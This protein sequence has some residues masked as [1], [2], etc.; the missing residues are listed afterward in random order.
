MAGGRL[1]DGPAGARAGG[2]RPFDL[3]HP[4]RLDPV[5]HLEVVEVLDADAAL[6]PLAHLADIV[7][8]AL[9]AGE[10]AGVH[11]D[12]IPDD[13]GLGRALD[14]AVPHRAAGDGAHL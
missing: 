4:E 7:L 8:E 14:D 1:A 12:A 10:G 2:K 9:E 5:A 6:E 13:P 11:G 3:F